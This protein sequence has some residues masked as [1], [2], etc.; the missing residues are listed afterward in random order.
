MSYAAG[1]SAQEQVW[2]KD[3]RYGEGIGIRAGDFELHPGI[4]GEFGYD[5]NYF[6]R[7]SNDDP[8]PVDT[9]RLRITPSFSVATINRGRGEDGGAP[10]PPKVGFRAAVAG[11]YSEFIALQS[12]NSDQLS[13]QRNISGLASLQLR[14]LPGR[15]FGGDVYTDALRS[16]QPS[17]DPTFNYNRFTARFGGGV[18]WA[19]GG[20]M[21]DWRLG[22]EYGLVYFE[23]RSFRGL[24]NESHILNTRGRWRFLPRTAVLFDGSASFLHYNQGPTG[25]QLDSNPIRARLGLNGLVT[26]QLALL[27]MAGWASSFYGG[28][29][30]QQFD[31]VV[32]QAE[33][34]WFIT[35]GT[36]TELIG[37]PLPISTAALG[38]TRDFYN[39]YLGDFIARHRFYFTLSHLFAG[40]FLIVIDGSYSPIRYPT[41]Y[42]PDRTFN[43]AGFTAPHVDAS[44]FG[45]YRLS[46]SFGLN[47]TFRYSANITDE[48]VSLD[49]LGWNRYEAFLGVRWFL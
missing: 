8:A 35:P 3:R 29:N 43:H 12:A 22:Y 10:E 40:R 5:S 20:G 42:N 18:T 30:A 6:L 14:I 26:R 46:D 21:F 4:G 16:V 34:K 2:L 39:S 28:A 11:T 24:S 13:K 15:P 1:A 27:A 36:G 48:R 17:N 31:G 7:S 32:A 49:Y 45:E 37:G 25:A 38:Y 23:D 47:A 19:P 41:I 33:L 9:L 44:L